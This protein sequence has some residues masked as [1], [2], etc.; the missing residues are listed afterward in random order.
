MT[1]EIEVKVEFLNK[2]YT[3]EEFVS[4][5]L[6]QEKVKHYRALAEEG[7]K[8]AQSGEGFSKQDPELVK[9]IA[10]AFA[11]EKA[12]MEI[13]DGPKNNVM[14]S[15]RKKYRQSKNQDLANA[16]QAILDNFEK[17][18]NGLK[19]KERMVE[20]FYAIPDVAKFLKQF[21]FNMK[22][23]HSGEY[24]L[25]I[26]KKFYFPVEY[27]RVGGSAYFRYF[28]VV[29]HEI[30][31]VSADPKT[32]KDL[33][34]KQ[35]E[36]MF[37]N[38]FVPQ[39]WNGCGYCEHENESSFD[40]EL[41]QVVEVHDEKCSYADKELDK[42][43]VKIKTSG[44][45]LIANNLL[46]LLSTKGDDRDKIYAYAREH[47]LNISLNSFDGQVGNMTAYAEV[48]NL[49][50]IQAGNHGASIYKRSDKHVD[51]MFYDED[52]KKPDGELS[53][54]LWAVNVMD[55]KS[56]KKYAPES[57]WKELIGDYTVID[58]KPG[59]YEVTSFSTHE[60]DLYDHETQTCSNAPIGNLKWF[61][62]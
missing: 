58:V 29:E 22:N 4:T 28:D 27:S 9:S 20:F 42:M 15:L 39:F 25:S 49:G 1:Q 54:S 32:D 2:D 13:L 12:L 34:E 10:E 21:L 40:H 46:N 43:T 50:Y 35:I 33:F 16:K 52:D 36:N 30:L 37:E 45:L 17:L 57:E 55:Y 5:Y 62:E 19:N 59:T 18:Y 48:F 61:S 53:L 51:I 41:M 24:E 26:D 8:I 23:K 11:W 47:N 7:R 44:K 14:D 56:A 38:I 6:N 3:L 31:K 60:D